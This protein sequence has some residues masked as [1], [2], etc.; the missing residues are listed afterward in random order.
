M[1]FGSDA[2]NWGQTS[3]SYSSGAGNL[4]DPSLAKLGSTYWLAHTCVNGITGAKWCLTSSSDLQSWAAVTTISTSGLSSD[5]ACAPEWVK[6]A[7]NSIYVD[8]NGCPHIV[9]AD[10]NTGSNTFYIAEQH[11]TGTCTGSTDLATASWTTPV[12]LTSM[13]TYMLDPFAVYDGTNF[14]LFYVDLVLS[15]NQSIQYGTASTLTGTYTKQSSGNWTGFQNGA[16]INQ[17]G[18]ALLCMSYSGSCSSWRIFFDQIGSAPGD[19]ADGQIFYANSSSLGSGWG[20]PT[21]INTPVQAKH[22]TVIPYP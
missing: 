22:G 11:P 4:R 9:Y 17:E 13:D 1:F 15:T 6:N 16:Q 18:P 2:A 20:V 7:N 5:N 8:S 21:N 19:L 14:N 12:A 10:C 3:V